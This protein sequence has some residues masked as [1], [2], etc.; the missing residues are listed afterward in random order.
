V[1]TDIDVSL[2][3]E[4]DE[5]CRIFRLVI[6][7]E[8]QP[9]VLKASPFLASRSSYFYD[10]HHG[11]TR[12]IRYHDF[13]TRCQCSLPCSQSIQCISAMASQAENESRM[14]IR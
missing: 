14:A 12:S 10:S 7:T 11:D 1:G 6:L 13:T 9:E 8:K 5:P 4:K 2:L 3:D